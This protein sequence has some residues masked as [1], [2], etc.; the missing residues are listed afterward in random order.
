[1]KVETLI[2]VYI[3]ICIS[4]IAF[5]CMYVLVL[6]YDA[7]KLFR[8][9]GKYS[10]EIRMQLDRL[11]AGLDIADSHKEGLC[12]T[13][14]KIDNLTAFDR[15]IEGF[16]RK[17][18][19]T[20]KQYLTGIHTVFICLSREYRGRDTIKAAYF[21][22]IISKYDILLRQTETGIT[23]ALFALLRSPD[24]YCR[25]NALKAIYSTG[26]CEDA[27]RALRLLDDN[28]GFHHPKL[29]CDGLMGFRGDKN[30]LGQRLLEVL[31]T[32]TVAMQVNILNFIRFA[33]VRCDETML[34]LLTDEGKNQEL[35]FCA[36]R[37]FEKFP[38]ASACE[39]L[40]DIAENKA[41]RAWEYPAIASSALK[42]YPGRRTAEI[43]E[44]NLSHPNWYVRL[45]SAVSCEK[46]GLSYTDLIQVFDGE[47]RYARDMIRYQLDRKEARQ[48]VAKA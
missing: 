28:P 37:Y 30:I 23:D 21:P 34:D 19:E 32:Y 35:R 3:A 9:T 33:G 27:V 1:M 2:Y 31:S 20:I 26:V 25:E 29:V 38:A 16:Y 46:L 24:V 15:S 40:Q 39:V 7:K 5:N 10:R 47:D 41:D 13:L 36:I 8:E 12:K 44:A 17:N 48:E 11:A 4:L 18:P 42:A 6:R 45:N 43:L 22:Y 14:K